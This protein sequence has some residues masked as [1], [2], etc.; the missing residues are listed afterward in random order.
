MV[1]MPTLTIR[2]FRL[3]F[4]RDRTGSSELESKVYFSER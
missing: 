2:F 3:S 1:G 4:R